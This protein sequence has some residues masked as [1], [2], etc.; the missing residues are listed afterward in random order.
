MI[1]FLFIIITILQLAAGL[2]VVLCTPGRRLS[3]S[4]SILSLIAV[5]AVYSAFWAVIVLIRFG[6]SKDAFPAFYHMLKSGKA[7]YQDIEYLVTAV[8]IGALLSVSFGFYLRRLVHDDQ[9]CISRLQENLIIVCIGVSLIYLFA[10]FR[11]A[12]R[13]KNQVRL[14]E[15]HGDGSLKEAESGIFTISD[16]IRLKN[17]GENDIDLKELYLSDKERGTETLSLEGNIIPSGGELVLYLDSASPFKLSKGETVYITDKDGRV[18]DSLFYD[19]DSEVIF[20]EPVFS[21]ENGF[22]S[23][24]FSLSITMPEKVPDDAYIAYTLDGSAPTADSIRYSSPVK[25]YDRKGEE[26]PCHDAKRVVYDYADYVPEHGDMDRAFIIRAAV[27]DGRGNRSRTVNGTFFIGDFEYEDRKII[28]L[29]ADYEALFGP[30]GICTTGPLYDAWYLGGQNGEAPMPNFEQSGR[31]FEAEANLQ[32]FNNG[33]CIG[34]QDVGLRVFGGSMRDFAKK[35]FSVYSRNTYS[36]SDSFSMDLFDNGRP[37][38]SIALRDGLSD[39]VLHELSKERDVASQEHTRVIVFLNGEFWFDTFACEKYSPAYFYEHKGIAENNIIIVKEGLIDTGMEGDELLY[40]QIY[41]YIGEHD[42]GNQ[43]SY[44]EFCNIIDVQSYI[45]Y[46][47]VTAYGCNLDQDEIINRQ[48]YRARKSVDD[49]ENDGRWRWA[50]YDMDLLDTLFDS[51]DY[52]GVDK[53]YEINPYT[54][55]ITDESVNIEEQTLFRALMQNESFRQRF[56]ET[57]KDF[58][59]TDYS[60]EN[61]DRVLEEYGGDTKSLR[62]FFKHRAEYMTEFTGQEFGME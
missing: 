15:L 10:G 57:M 22:Y 18:Y 17:T 51:T 37:V 24:G 23:D 5:G 1:L 12:D 11:N 20:E 30:N 52:F 46:L 45:D 31:A 59:E 25:V 29:T 35:H 14:A 3:V 43:D 44:E 28:S 41:Q 13:S 7:F 50:L 6:G 34:G 49:G 47:C 4:R 8:F 38:H 42:L 9:P 54:E 39:A 61:V 60:M 36:G 53:A 32:Y 62:N 33:S 55:R 2:S 26:A 58:I 21:H 19:P 48:L 40:Q 16:F 56:A 27:F